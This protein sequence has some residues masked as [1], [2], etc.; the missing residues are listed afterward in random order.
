M[1]LDQDA[2]GQRFFRVGRLHRYRSLQD[3][4]ARVYPL[5]DEVDR[6]AGDRDSVDERL[7]LSVQSGERRQQR[8]VDVHQPSLPDAD[9]HRSQEAH[10][11]GQADEADVVALE[12][13]RQHGL[14]G[15]P[16]AVVLRVQEERGHTG[17]RRALEGAGILTVGSDDDDA[18][19]IAEPGAGLQQRLEIRAATGGEDADAEDRAH[20]TSRSR[21]L[22]P[23]WAQI[24]QRSGWRIMEESRGKNCASDQSSATWICLRK[25]TSLYRWSAL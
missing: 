2:G 6:R 12:R 22:A 17:R 25:P 7:P 3:D 14:I 15:G 9:E 20:A 1:L 11:T 13:L 23:G 18:R 24:G 21:G 8:G 16:G 10:E 4:R 5:V 19:R